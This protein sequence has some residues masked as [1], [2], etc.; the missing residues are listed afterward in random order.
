MLVKSNPDTKF[1]VI[2][3]DAENVEK[4]GNFANE[5]ISLPCA[6]LS[7]LMQLLKLENP[8]QRASNFMSDI[9]TAKEILDR[10]F[11]THSRMF[12]TMAE[13]LQRG[14]SVALDQV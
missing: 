7:A 10:E 11:K 6:A 12:M 13:M 1:R 8:V 14:S 4:N 9:Q 3:L 2:I 5:D